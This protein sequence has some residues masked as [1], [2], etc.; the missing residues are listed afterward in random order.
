MAT[1]PQ[2]VWFNGAVVPWDDACLH[3]S[4]ATVLRGANIFEG[5][6]AYWNAEERDL[7]LFR[8][9]AHLARLWESAKIMRMTIPW[10]AGQLTEAEVAVLR[11]NAFQE[12]VWFRLTLYVGEGEESQWPPETIPI[13]GFILPRLSPRGA[14]VRE[15]IDSCTSTWQRISDTSVP[16]RVKAGANYHNARLAIMEA[17]MSG[18]SGQPI[19]LNER[20]KVAEG[21]A[22]CVFL[23]RRGTLVTPPVTSNILESVTRATLLELARDGLGIPTEE[24]EVDRT[25]LY[26]CEEAFFC[27]SG[28]EIT[29]INSVDHYPVGDGRPGQITRRLQDLY[30]SV[31][32]GRVERYRHWLTPVCHPARTAV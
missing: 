5:I 14:S 16:P 11:A 3:V 30:F 8:N 2:F 26:V 4:T 10:T 22:A 32:E 27:G 1:H 25:E 31:V 15:G 17:R 28:W 18:Y 23:V 19:M 12:T 13:G 7:Y 6:R 9:D 24:R 29:P 21:P 20:G